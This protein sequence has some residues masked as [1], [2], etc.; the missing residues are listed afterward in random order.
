MLN[1]KACMEPSLFP[2][3]WSQQCKRVEFVCKISSKNMDERN[4]QI[5]ELDFHIEVLYS[6]PIKFAN[7]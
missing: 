2:L 6:N 4:Y 7:E 3:V 1:L 5:N